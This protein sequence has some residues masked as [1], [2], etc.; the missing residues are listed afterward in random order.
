MQIA[1]AFAKRGLGTT[2]P[3]PSVGCVI[4]KDNIIIGT[5]RT[6]IG[7][8]P[9]G[10][11]EALKMAGDRAKGADAYVTLEP[12]SYHGET[13]PCA[14]ALIDAGVARVIIGVEDPNPKVSGAGIEMLREAGIEAIVGV[15]EKECYE[16]NKGFFL[17]VT[18]NRPLVT[19]KVASTID[20]KIGTYSGDS[21]WITSEKAREYGHMLRATHDAILVGRGTIDADNPR[22]DCRL[23]GLSHQSPVRLVLGREG[24]KIRK[25]PEVPLLNLCGEEEVRAT[26]AKCGKGNQQSTTKSILSALAENGITRLLIEGGSKVFTSFIKEDVFDEIY[27]FTAPKIMGEPSKPAVCDLDIQNLVDVKQLYLKESINIGNDI[28]NVFVKQSDNYL[29]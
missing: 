16:I 18:E 26:T 5:G 14:K 29:S 9:H 15:Y 13:P 8:R 21:K 11:T 4:I 12:C 1:I 27:W 17:T 23:P 2:A 10:E 6:G 7:G 19:I 24:V 22:L 28:L 20:G 25:Y 3:N